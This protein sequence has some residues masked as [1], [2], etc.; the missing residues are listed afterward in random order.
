LSWQV[1]LRPPVI[2]ICYYPAELA[3]Q[4]VSTISQTARSSV[5]QPQSLEVCLNVPG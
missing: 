1:S 5:T 2:V 3:K 4:D